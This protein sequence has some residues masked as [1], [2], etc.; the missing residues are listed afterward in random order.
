MGKPK[1]SI[2]W[3]TS[4]CRAKQSEIWASGV[5]IQSTQSTF[6]SSVIKVILGSFGVL[7][8][9]GPVTVPSGIPPLGQPLSDRTLPTVAGCVR[10]CKEAAS[11]VTICEGIPMFDS[12]W[13]EMS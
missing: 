3:E 12:L 4:E 11:H 8:I 9:F 5:S 1:T 2:I 10:L 6:D 7:Q 13:I